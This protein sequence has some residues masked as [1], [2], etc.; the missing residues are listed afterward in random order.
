MN[1]IKYV[2]TKLSTMVVI[3]FWFTSLK[4]RS[5]SIFGLVVIRNVGCFKSVITEAIA[6]FIPVKSLNYLANVLACNLAENDAFRRSA[7][8]SSKAKTKF[9]FL[10]SSILTAWFTLKNR[11]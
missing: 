1:R 10:V 9:N 4:I 2:E 6:A 7:F 3:S 11:S 5:L 8:T